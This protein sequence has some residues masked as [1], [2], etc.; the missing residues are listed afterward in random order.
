MAASAIETHAVVFVVFIFI[1]V[2]K[3]VVHNCLSQG[4]CGVV[5][6]LCGAIVVHLREFSDDS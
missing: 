5:G 1:K 2:L 6:V 3:E 4:L